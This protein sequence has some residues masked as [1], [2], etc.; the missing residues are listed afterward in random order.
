MTAD[1]KPFGFVNAE[2]VTAFRTALAS[3]LLI[4]R[5]HRV[6]TLLVFGVGKQA[7]W[8][9]RLSLLIHGPSIKKVHFVNREFSERGRNIL[10][11]FIRFDEDQKE[12]EGWGGCQFDLISQSYKE[13][14]RILKDQMRAA[15][16]IF[17]TTPSTAPLFDESILTN[18]EGRKKGRLIVAVGSYK[19]T[20]IE[21]PKE[22]IAQAVKRHGPGHHFHKHAEEGGVIVVD[23]LACLTETGELA[24]LQPNQSVELGELVMIEEM[25][26][27]AEHQ[28]HILEGGEF[29]QSLE[30]LSFDP[31]K[32]SSMAQVMREDSMDSARSQSTTVLASSTNGSTTST[33]AG[34]PPSRT[35]S[36]S[37]RFRKRTGSSSSQKRQE[38]KDEHMGRWLSSGNVIYKSVGMGLMDLVVGGDLVKLA[39]ERNVGT[40]ITDF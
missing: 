24:G 15:D 28:P 10:K 9:V 36:K 11:K 31:S 19:S 38:D 25:A 30:A 40:T 29:T 16:I 2:E 21:I 22:I 13:I 18:T 33:G 27:A 17:C 5:R 34:K 23:T 8:H 1:G 37:S 26:P 3:S 7:Y 32:G 35:S 20:M 6:K 12:S 39:R 4:T 14:D